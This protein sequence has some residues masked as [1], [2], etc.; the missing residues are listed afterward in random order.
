MKKQPLSTPMSWDVN[1]SI[2]KNPLLWFQLFMVALIASSYLMLLMVGINLFEH[3]WEDI[4]AS[5][6]VGLVVGGSLFLTF[7]LILFLMYWRGIPTKYILNDSHIEQYTLMRGKKTVGLLG[8]FGILSGKSA[9]YT[10]AGATLLARSREQIAVE[11]KDATS[12]E[13]FPVRHEIQLHNDWRT[14]MQVVCPE[15]QFENILQFIR[16]KI[17]KIKFPEKIKEEMETSFA[18]KVILSLFSLIFG[19]FLFPR[20]P[21]HFV[22]IFAIAT[23]IFAFLALWSSDLK[24]RVFGGILFLLPI[25]GVVLAFVW[26]EVDMTHQGSIYALLIELLVLSY[27]MLLGMGVALK[28][29]R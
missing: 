29:V 4:P 27:F 23:I 21:I 7:S 19:I 2:L 8:L 11:W 1:I 17:E 6:S 22:G 3:H 26:G 9:G 24:Q 10:V 16:K 25:I 28:Y 5:L 18:K 12:L 20:L 14:I 15:D 13:V